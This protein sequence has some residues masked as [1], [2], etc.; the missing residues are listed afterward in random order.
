ME[1]LYFVGT[2]LKKSKFL[3]SFHYLLKPG[4]ADNC[5]I[6]SQQFKYLKCYAKKLYNS[7]DRYAIESPMKTP[8]QTV[9]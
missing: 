7:R 1:Y 3:V 2:R 4:L 6:L 8:S 9:I 5:R